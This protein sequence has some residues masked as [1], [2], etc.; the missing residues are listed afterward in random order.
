MSVVRVFDLHA[1]EDLIVSSNDSL[2]AFRLIRTEYVKMPPDE[3]GIMLLPSS[4]GRQGIL[5]A[6]GWIR[7]GWEGEV[8]VELGI[9]RE[10]VI[11]KGEPI[12]HVV[13]FKVGRDIRGVG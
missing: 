4:L 12:I 6:G 8:A 3:L 7:P 10:C 13:V 9:F 1:Q 11:R 2:P 5:F